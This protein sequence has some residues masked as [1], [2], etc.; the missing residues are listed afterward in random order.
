MV[1]LTEVREYGQTDRSKSM[2]RLT[3]VREYGQ[4]DRNEGV[5]SD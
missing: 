1:R 3:E 5:W 2:V 4:T